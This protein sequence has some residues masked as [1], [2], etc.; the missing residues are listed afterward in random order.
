MSI[1]DVLCER[2]FAFKIKIKIVVGK[3]MTKHQ[4]F[5]PFFTLKNRDESNTG[6]SKTKRIST[7]SI[8]KIDNFN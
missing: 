4:N 8:A 1:R 2:P 7:S 6:A 5:D 3:P